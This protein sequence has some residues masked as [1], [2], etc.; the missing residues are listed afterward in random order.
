MRTQS[1]LAALLGI[2]LLSACA[3]TGTITPVGKDTY[4]ITAKARGGMSWSDIKALA[5]N[6]ASGHCDQRQRHMLPI[7]ISTSGVRGWTPQEASLTFR[8]VSDD[9]PDW[10]NPPPLEER[11]S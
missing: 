10:T 5:L 1:R 2:G 9:D 7:R 11:R 6:D 3:S 4:L 8:C